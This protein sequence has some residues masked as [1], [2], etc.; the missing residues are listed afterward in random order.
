MSPIMNDRQARL[1][2]PKLEWKKIKPGKVLF[3][4]VALGPS[5]EGEI[6]VRIPALP[7]VVSQG[8]SESEALENIKEALRGA[9]E[10]YH[11]SSDPIPWQE[12]PG[13]DPDETSKWIQ[14]D[15]E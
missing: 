10:E 13:C 2:R 15:V 7:G 4:R 14:V 6:P 1:G 8:R 5:E 11:A 3:I 9:I 12:D